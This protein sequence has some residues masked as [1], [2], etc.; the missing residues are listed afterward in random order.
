MAALKALN[1]KPYAF[2]DDNFLLDENKLFGINVLTPSKAKKLIEQNANK[3]II[4]VTSNYF[5]TIIESVDQFKLSKKVY[6]LSPFK[7]KISEESCFGLI[8]YSDAIRK[9]EAHY[10][11][12]KQFER[13]IESKNNSGINL[14]FLDIQLT[15][16]CTMKC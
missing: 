14:A 4:I 13:K 5:E 6:N 15:E 9:L 11:K 2:I 12:S 7:E 8:S 10:S 3:Y 16:R 1:L